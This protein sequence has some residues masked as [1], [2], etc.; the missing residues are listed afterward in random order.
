MSPLHEHK[1]ANTASDPQIGATST[2][3]DIIAA[4][5]FRRTERSGGL[6]QGRRA[7]RSCCCPSTAIDLANPLHRSIGARSRLRRSYLPPSAAPVGT[8]CF[9]S[10][11]SRPWRRSHIHVWVPPRLQRRRRS[12]GRLHWR[13]LPN[14]S[15]TRCSR[16]HRHALAASR[17]GQTVRTRE[18]H[19][20]PPCKRAPES[21]ICWECISLDLRCCERRISVQ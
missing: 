15:P 5:P 12:E 3:H 10:D 17:L 19:H 1:I 6:T 9:R 13:T 18:L 14:T 16:A 11:E 21:Q 8:L 20:C 4:R 2:L 7:G